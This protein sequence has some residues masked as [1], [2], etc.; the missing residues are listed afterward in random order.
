MLHNLPSAVSAA[1]PLA[2]HNQRIETPF[3]RIA[4]LRVQFWKGLLNEISKTGSISRLSSPNLH[5][6]V[7]RNLFNAP[8][9]TLH[10]DHIIQSD[11]LRN[12]TGT[13]ASRSVAMLFCAANSR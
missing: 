6:N 9:F 4:V 13:P 8:P 7:G 10:N 2:R 1:H 5:H 11:G 3:L 12:G